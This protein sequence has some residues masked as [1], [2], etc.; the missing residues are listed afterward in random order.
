MDLEKLIFLI[1]AILLSVFSMYR[2]SRKKAQ[3]IPDKEDSFHDFFEPQEV[4]NPS[5]PII[6]FEQNDES[7]LTPTNNILTKNQKKKQKP[8]NIEKVVPNKENSKIILQDAD[9]ES[10]SLLLENFEGTEIQRAFLYSEI[11]KTLKDK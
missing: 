1:I 8:Q 7:K 4:Y 3:S 9:L 2:K 5:E 11:F 10:N 6:I